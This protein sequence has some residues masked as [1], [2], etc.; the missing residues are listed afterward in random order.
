MPDDRPISTDPAAVIAAFT[1]REL[2]L[3]DLARVSPTCHRVAFDLAGTSIHMLVDDA[4]PSTFMLE[5]P[6]P[7]Q[8]DLDEEAVP[9][10]LATINELHESLPH[11]RF[12]L[13]DASTGLPSLTARFT[14]PLIGPDR[15]RAVREAFDLGID[16]L[17]YAAAR[18]ESAF[19]PLLIGRT[20]PP[21]A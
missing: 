6:E 14:A 3:R 2:S 19:D 12:L 7:F 11:V 20:A 18:C 4:A 13:R 16:A 8:L 21:P 1:Q 9:A 5:F 10:A 17:F 15:T